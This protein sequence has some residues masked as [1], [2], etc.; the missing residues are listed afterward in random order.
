MLLA[1]AVLYRY[2]WQKGLYPKPGAPSSP[3]HGPWAYDLFLQEGVR[4][5]LNPPFYA[6]VFAIL[7]LIVKPSLR[8]GVALALSI[9]FFFIAFGHIG[10][11]ED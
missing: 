4:W 6:F 2:A 1:L 11:V 5:L 10:L 7:S 3:A 8:A 9:F